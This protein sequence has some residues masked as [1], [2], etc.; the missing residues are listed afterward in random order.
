M[1]TGSEES[2]RFVVHKSLLDVIFD[3]FGSDVKL[4]KY[5][6]EN[7]M[8]TADVQVSPIFI[9]WCC[10]FGK[11]VKV[12]SPTNVVE[13]VKEYVKNIYEQYE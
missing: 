6:E 2:V 3:R 12:V 1:F 7:Y 9:G 11:K 5:D 10:A 8:F 13:Q 4:M